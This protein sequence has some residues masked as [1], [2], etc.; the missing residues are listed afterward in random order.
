MDSGLHGS[1]VDSKAAK[2]TDWTAARRRNSCDVM[3]GTR[4]DFGNPKRS[5]LSRATPA[6]D[7]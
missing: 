5:R 1:L 7:S 4:Y 6:L 3:S 2:P